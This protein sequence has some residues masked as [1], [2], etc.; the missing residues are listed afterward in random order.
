MWYNGKSPIEL[1]GDA[2]LTLVV[3]GTFT[4]TGGKAGDGKNPTGSQA[5]RGYAGINVPSGTT[6]TV[7]GH[8]NL[9]AQGG[10]AGDGGIQ[11]LGVEGQVDIGG[12][13]G[14]GAGAG[15]G[16]NGG[17]GGTPNIGNGQ[18]GMDAGVINLLDNVKVTA[19]GGAGG[20]GGG[21]GTIAGVTSTS[22][23]GGGGY[24]A[25]GI[26]G[27]GAGGGGGGTA[28]GGGGFSGGSGETDGVKRE[29]GLGGA[30][31]R[32]RNWHSGGGGYFAQGDTGHTTYSY[33]KGGFIGGSGSTDGNSATSISWR[34]GNGGAGGSGGTVKKSNAGSLVVNNGTYYTGNKKIWGSN[35]TPIYAQ[36]GYSLDTIRNAGITNI[37]A[38]TK[39]SLETELK[40]LSK[41]IPT[42]KLA[43]VGSGAGYTE[44]SNGK[45]FF[46]SLPI[47]GEC[48]IVNIDK[49]LMWKVGS[50]H[51]LLLSV[52]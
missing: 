36:S 20:A 40:S 25:A 30:V 33:Y 9:T 49:E 6:L 41:A 11:Q 47:N 26:G 22:G 13:G 10:P 51:F 24:P 23:G 18:S 39:G 14:G 29:N 48:V 27:G 28:A 1:Q 50:A 17:I 31:G 2:N 15:I 37:A 8:G 12:G 3:D 34:G 4:V 44:T 43:G 52:V 16:G 46:F 19:N 5:A 38:R 42:A 45:I 32:A 21:T 7:M 35:P